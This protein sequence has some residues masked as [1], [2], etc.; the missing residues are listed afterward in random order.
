[1]KKIIIIASILCVF[2]VFSTQ[3][4]EQKEINLTLATMMT[5][6][7]AHC[8]PSVDMEKVFTKD[9]VVFTGFV[10]NSNIFQIFINKDGAWTSMLQNVSGISCIYFSGIPGILKSPQDK[11]DGT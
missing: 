8:A 10:D 5:S 7:P 1:M 9:Q 6:L 4:E 2:V 11:K 3:A